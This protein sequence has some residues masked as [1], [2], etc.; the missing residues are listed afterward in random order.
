MVDRVQSGSA[1]AA[2]G[3]K[4]GDVIERADDRRIDGP[5]DL[6]QYMGKSGSWPRGKNDLTL[7]VRTGAEAPR[8]LTIVPWT[9]RLHPTQL[10]E[11]VS[12]ALLFLLLSAYYPF[13][14]HDGQVMALMMIG[15]SMHRYVNELLRADERPVG[16]EAWT[17]VILFAGGVLLWLWLARRP[18]QYRLRMKEEA[19]PRM[20]P[21]LLSEPEA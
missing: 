16:F 9:L 13:R 1:A 4:P 11:T 19:A 7:E 6:D 15:Y 21:V 2:K 10:Y 3:L 20:K 17:S 12:M 5:G 18:A 8:T 14:R